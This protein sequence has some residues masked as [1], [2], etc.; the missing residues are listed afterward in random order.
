MAAQDNQHTA[1]S[2]GNQHKDDIQQRLLD[3]AAADLSK[4]PES[5]FG[6]RRATQVRRRLRVLSYDSGYSDDAPPDSEHI[7]ADIVAD[8]WDRDT[9]QAARV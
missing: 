7:D 8:R 3:M 5:S 1:N 6:K 9:D 2:I 4:A